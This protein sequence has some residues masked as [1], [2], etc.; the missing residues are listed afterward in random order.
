M[1]SRPCVD[2]RPIG[3]ALAAAALVAGA[4]IPSARAQGEKISAEALFEDGRRLVGEGKYAEACPKFLASQRLDPSAGTLLNLASCLEKQGLVASAWQTYKEAASAADAAG[5]RD[6]VG[7][8]QRH[9]EALVPRLARLTVNVEQPVDGLHVK[10]DGVVV[11]RAEWGVPIPVDTGS[12]TIE[13]AAPAHKGWAAAAVVGQ[14]GAQVKVTV[15]A[16]EA[17][18]EEA[19]PPAPPPPSPPGPAQAPPAGAGVVGSPGPQHAA[20]STQ[21]SIGWVVGGI[22]VVGLGVGAGLAVLA[23]SKNSSSLANCESASPNLCSPTGISERDSALS[24]G[25][26]STVAVGVGAAAV[27]GG[28]LLVFTAPSSSAAAA[29]W[30]VGPTPGGAVVRGTW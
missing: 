15:P 30:V 2:P 7:T 5:R 19:A 20:S 9:A 24:A 27:V 4:N 21:R 26:A 22:G 18:P 14:D 10:R 29:A 12:H 25:N 6:Y 28:L 3:V 13:A 16:L 17:A 11:D 1:T 23:K 8:A